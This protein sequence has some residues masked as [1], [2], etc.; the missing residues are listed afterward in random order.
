MPGRRR[1][2]VIP[3]EV[4][5]RGWIAAQDALLG[6]VAQT[7]LSRVGLNVLEQTERIEGVDVDAGKSCQWS[8]IGAERLVEADRQRLQSLL[9]GRGTGQTVGR[10]AQVRQIGN[11]EVLV[12]RAVC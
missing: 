6:H 5:G 10:L 2:N 1:V 4:T 7:E 3:E 12:L 11:D 8:K 9:R